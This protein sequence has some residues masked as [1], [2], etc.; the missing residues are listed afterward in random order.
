MGNLVNLPNITPDAINAFIMSGRTKSEHKDDDRF[1]KTYLD[2]RVPDGMTEKTITIRLLPMNLH[3]GEPWVR[4]Y[5]HSVKLNDI[6]KKM[7][8][9][10]YKT[11]V[12]VK[13]SP[14]IS[15]EIGRQCPFCEFNSRLYNDST[16]EQD[17][18]RKKSLQMQSLDNMA[19]ETIIVRCIER[20][21]EDEGV[22]FWKFNLRKDNMDP[23]H[24][25][26]SLYNQRKAEGERIGQ[27]I[28][29]LDIYNGRDLSITF[30]TGKPVP[31]PAIIDAGIQTPLSNDPEQ[32]RQWIYDTRTWQDVFPVK[33]YEYM[34][35]ILNGKIPWKDKESGKWIDKDIVDGKVNESKAAEDEKIRQAEAR[36]YGTAQPPVVQ[37]YTA[38]QNPYAYTPQQQ[39]PQYPQQSYG[40]QGQN[41]ME[42]VMMQDSDFLPR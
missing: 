16:N 20:G 26:L 30:K 37:P 41:V 19:K 9:S 3:T 15:S 42:Q 5:T 36:F 24:A 35:L 6:Q 14:D 39:L 2:T 8:K 17:P 21:K 22:K 23:Y 12:C 10:E 33:P 18:I 31:P 29:I 38:S 13:K 40:I 1:L 27:N 25:I 7:L 34:S 32:M 28:N 4:I 11:Y